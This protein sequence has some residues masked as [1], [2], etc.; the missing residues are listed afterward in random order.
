MR[1]NHPAIFAR[2]EMTES[3]T[4]R[5]GRT[6]TDEFAV[7]VTGLPASGKTTLGHTLTARIEK[8]F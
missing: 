8:E 1:R 2:N 6:T 5:A 3:P 7:L 4:A